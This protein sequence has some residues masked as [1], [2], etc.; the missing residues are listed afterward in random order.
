MSSLAR[1]ARRRGAAAEDLEGS[2][3]RV[4]ADAVVLQR[5]QGEGS[6]GAGLRLQQRA[7]DV[8]HARAL[9][10]T[11][12]DV[13]LSVP[14]AEA[15]RALLDLADEEHVHG[16]GGRLAVREEPRRRRGGRGP[17]RAEPVDLGRRR[18][19]DVGGGLAALRRVLDIFRT[20]G[21]QA[22]DEQAGQHKAD[23]KQEHNE[24]R[25][26]EVELVE[27]LTTDRY[28]HDCPGPVEQRHALQG[29]PVVG[30]QD[31]KAEATDVQAAHERQHKRHCAP[32]GARVS[33]RRLDSQADD[34]QGELRDAQV[35]RA[36]EREQV[37]EAVEVQAPAPDGICEESGSNP[38]RQGTYCN[39]L[40]PVRQQ[41]QLLPVVRGVRVAGR[42][43]HGGASSGQEKD[44]EPVRPAEALVQ[45]KRCKQGV[46]QQGAA[47]VHARGDSRRREEDGYLAK[48]LAGE[49][50]RPAQ[51]LQE[52]RDAADV[53]VGAD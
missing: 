21:G 20:S 41:C 39:R 18:R 37:R 1:K 24:L 32:G 2:Q 38:I 16:A 8:R 33:W 51:P 6:V 47:E 9:P 5:V 25:R 42:P 14:L 17:R 34:L 45:D 46:P 11:R 26:R 23:A 50:P 43:R 27:E 30:R 22:R 12:Y 48:D 36:H 3:R 10:R 19:R 35:G 40:W 44:P 28:L 49:P 29:L 31:L 4:Q 7:G 53:R 13:V 15:H 52:P